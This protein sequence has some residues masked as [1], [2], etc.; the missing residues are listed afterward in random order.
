MKQLEWLSDAEFA[1]GGVKFH[2]AHADYTLETDPERCVPPKSRDALETYAKALAEAPPRN[3]LEF[4]IFQGG[5]PALF[6]A[7]LDLDKVVGVDI[8]EPV[9][10]FDDFCRTHE[11]GRKIRTYYRVSQADKRW[12]DQIVGTEFGPAPLDM[13]VDDASHLYGA[14]RSTFEFAFPH[15][16]PGGALRRARRH[17]ARKSVGV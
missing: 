5:S 10:S 12:I 4:G 15:L 7:W 1:V 9:E 6:A 2:C 14:T 16:R 13:I 8:C 11:I 3:V 17:I